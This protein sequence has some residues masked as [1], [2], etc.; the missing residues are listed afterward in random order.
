M[1]PNP[2]RSN[3]LACEYLLHPPLW[4]RRGI[5]VCAGDSSTR[6]KLAKFWLQHS[7][8]VSFGMAVE[9]PAPVV[10]SEAVDSS[11]KQMPPKENVE[12]VV[13]T[14][15]QSHCWVTWLPGI[16]GVLIKFTQNPFPKE[17]ST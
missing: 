16:I 11:R 12:T 14:H 10:V 2:P 5:P 3:C 8:F 4:H 6:G 17:I 9:Q 7:C 13:K 15:Q 1:P